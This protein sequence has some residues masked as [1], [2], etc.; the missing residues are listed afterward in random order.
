MTEPGDTV[1]EVML[2]VQMRDPYII[3]ENATL[4]VNT[5]V[6]TSPVAIT[7]Y[8][9]VRNPIMPGAKLVINY[10]EQVGVNVSAISVTSPQSSSLEGVRL[11]LEKR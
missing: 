10:P 4:I 9:Y 3:R 2:G 7:I 5:D 1:T 8:F 6:A 11:A